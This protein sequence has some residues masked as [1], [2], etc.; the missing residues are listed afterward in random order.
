[1]GDAA[2]AAGVATRIDVGT[3]TVNDVVVPTADPRVAFGGVGKSGYG[4][5]RGV[6]GLRSMTRPKTIAVRGGG[7]RLHLRPRGEFDADRMARATR[8]WYG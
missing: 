1:M 5:T 6:E 4:V 8:W 3:V 2:E 7:P